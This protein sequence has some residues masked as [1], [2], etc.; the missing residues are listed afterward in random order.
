MD[1]CKPNA[2]RPTRCPKSGGL[3]TNSCT[4]DHGRTEQTSNVYSIRDLKMCFFSQCCWFHHC[5]VGLAYI[6]LR[7]LLGCPVDHSWILIK[8]QLIFVIFFFFTWSILVNLVVLIFTTIIIIKIVSLVLLGSVSN[9][10]YTHHIKCRQVHTGIKQW[11]H[12]IVTRI[13]NLPLRFNIWNYY[14]YYKATGFFF[15]Y[16]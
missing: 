10:Y 13:T 11:Q 15:Y 8:M 2:E 14:Y 3:K 4:Q 6:H 7:L 1:V 12:V 9:D 16:R 5:F